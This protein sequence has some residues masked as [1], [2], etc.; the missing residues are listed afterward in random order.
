MDK[1]EESRESVLSRT[2]YDWLLN[3]RKE[4]SQPMAAFLKLTAMNLKTARA[5]RIKKTASSL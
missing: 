4:G 3:R 2:R 1:E 5:W